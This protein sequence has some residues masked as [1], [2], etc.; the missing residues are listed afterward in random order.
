M[1]TKF[2]ILLGPDSGLESVWKMATKFDNGSAWSY[3]Q[4]FLFAV[5]S[6][7]VNDSEAF[8]EADFLLSIAHMR[9]HL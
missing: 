6:F 3:A 8:E 5:R 7:M 2:E 4:G 1:K 9:E